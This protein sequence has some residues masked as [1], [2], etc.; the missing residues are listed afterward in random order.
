MWKRCWSQSYY[1]CGYCLEKPS[2]QYTNFKLLLHNSMHFLSIIYLVHAREFHYFP[3]H[4]AARENIYFCTVLTKIKANTISIQDFPP[5]DHASN[6]WH[7]S[8]MRKA[9]KAKDE[10]SEVWYEALCDS[11]KVLFKYPLKFRTSR[12]TLVELSCISS[13]NKKVYLFTIIE[14]YTK[15]MYSS[16]LNQTFSTF[17]YWLTSTCRTSSKYRNLCPFLLALSRKV[18][19]FS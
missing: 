12:P 10:N 4:F 7:S 6:Q 3:N 5:I 9:L 16:F 17:L 2:Y 14:R 11:E 1:L 18:C 19:L 8:S 13:Q 15:K